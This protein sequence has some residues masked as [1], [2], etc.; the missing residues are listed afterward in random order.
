MAIVRVMAVFQGASLL[1]EDRFV[2][3]FHF[4]NFGVTGSAV[5]E[6][7]CRDAVDEFYNTPL[8]G[9]WLGEHMSPYVNRN[10]KIVSYNMELPAGERV[11]TEQ[12]STLGVG[13]TQGLPEEVAICLT[14]EAAPPVTPRRRGRLYFGP[15]TNYTQTMEPGSTSNPA[16]PYKAS[17]TSVVSQL[18]GRA[19]ILANR[20]DLDWSIRSVTP[21][22]NYVRIVGGYVDDAFDTQRRRGPDP[23]TR[24]TWAATPDV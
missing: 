10:F 17:V 1:P 12:G 4:A 16:R 11:P 18:V 5:F 9:S 22:E 15:L 19:Q 6:E 14:L 23:T 3:T 2:N 20:H 7:A 21:V 8:T 24:V 13:A